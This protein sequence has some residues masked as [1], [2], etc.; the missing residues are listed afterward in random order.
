MSVTIKSDI[1]TKIAV[2]LELTMLS[3][4]LI[5]PDGFKV[6]FRNVQFNKIFTLKECLFGIFVISNAKTHGVTIYGGL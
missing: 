1:T 5:R 4:K 2:L 3:K 6:F